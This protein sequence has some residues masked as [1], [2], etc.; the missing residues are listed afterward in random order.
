MWERVRH[1][2]IK[3]F[4]QTFRNPRMRFVL[5]AP[6]LI[7]LVAYGYA[8]NLDISCIPTAV[9]D[10]EQTQETREI[11]RRF[12]RSGYFCLRARV[13]RTADLTVTTCT[14]ASSQG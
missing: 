2:V 14:G 5:L 7:Q 4:I 3:E 11:I 9:A 6:P 8:F 1:L 13:A 12:E 10:L